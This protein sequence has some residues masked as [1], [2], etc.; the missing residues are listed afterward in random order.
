MQLR[1]LPLYLAN[2]T[3]R[4]HRMLVDALDSALLRGAETGE[5]SIIIGIDS[6]YR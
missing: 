6:F 3:P 1:F 4:D 2:D 5:R